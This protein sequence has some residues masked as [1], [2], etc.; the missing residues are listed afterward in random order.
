MFWTFVNVNTHNSV[1]FI[2]QGTGICRWIFKERNQTFK[3]YIY[4]STS[5]D[6]RHDKALPLLKEMA[7]L[8]SF[9]FYENLK[10]E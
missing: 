6:N 4:I 7:L 9:G 10:I 2:P 1:S 5:D 3:I 8:I